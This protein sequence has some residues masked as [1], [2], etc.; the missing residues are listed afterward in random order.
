MTAQ[1][2]PARRKPECKLAFHVE[3]R[4][5]FLIVAIQGQTSF[6]QAEA[7]SAHLLRILLKLEAHFSL[8]VLDLAELPSISSLSMLVLVEFRMDLGRRGVEVRLANVQTPVWLA[9]GS[10]GFCKLFEPME[11]EQPTRPSAVSEA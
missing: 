4:P 1:T 5:H 11:L 8:V 7:M 9:L 10:A 3:R 6:D 2:I